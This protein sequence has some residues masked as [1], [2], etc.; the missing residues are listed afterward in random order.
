MTNDTIT[1]P[2]ITI[3]RQFLDDKATVIGSPDRAGDDCAILV[4]GIEVGES[5]WC[6]GANIPKG[7]R[8]ASTGKAG[9]SLGHPTREAAEQV[10]ADAYLASI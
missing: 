4:N 1:T 8:W 2:T 6:N 3:S 5:Y 10:Q 7:Q 9:I